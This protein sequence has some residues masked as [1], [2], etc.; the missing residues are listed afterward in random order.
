LR[1]P[2]IILSAGAVARPGSPAPLDDEHRDQGER[3][4]A[5]QQPEY[6]ITHRSLLLA[7]E[8]TVFP[9][10]EADC[11]LCHRVLLVEPARRA[12]ATAADHR[13]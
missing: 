9:A 12:A 6:D 8:S 7:I 3:W 2:A 11:G 1:P 10:D 13:R 5:D 4:H